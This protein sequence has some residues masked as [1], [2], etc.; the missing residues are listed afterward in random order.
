[1]VR[2]IPYHDRMNDA[3]DLLCPG[4]AKHGDKTIEHVSSLNFFRPQMVI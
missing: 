4:G 1:M 2:N 3:A